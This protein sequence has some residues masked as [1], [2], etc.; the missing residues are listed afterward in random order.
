MNRLSRNGIHP[1]ISPIAMCA[2][3]DELSF[4]WSELQ[5]KRS[6]RVCEVQQHTMRDGLVEMELL[7]LDSDRRTGYHLQTDNIARNVWKNGSC[8][9]SVADEQRW[10]K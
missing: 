2:K 10:T 9:F 1:I 6:I 7:L 8:A 4:G 3:Q 5:S